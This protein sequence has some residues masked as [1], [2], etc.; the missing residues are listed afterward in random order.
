[1]ETL[2]GDLCPGRL[3]DDEEETLRL[4][5]VQNSFNIL[6]LSSLKL[7]TRRM[8][9]ADPKMT[10]RINIIN[11]PEKVND[12]FCPW[13]YRI[14]IISCAMMNEICNILCSKTLTYYDQVL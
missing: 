1:M 8:L 6:V 14:T 2:G 12:G 4:Q 9:S 10:V 7:Y 5:T 13:S 11:V 3:P